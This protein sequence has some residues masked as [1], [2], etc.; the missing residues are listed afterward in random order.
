M[1]CRSRGCRGVEQGVIQ[2]EKK[3]INL[4]K[5]TLE[6]LEAVVAPFFDHHFRPGKTLLC[7]SIVQYLVP[8]LEEEIVQ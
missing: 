2:P 8:G 5:V 3:G 1:M 4:G 6:V 7:D